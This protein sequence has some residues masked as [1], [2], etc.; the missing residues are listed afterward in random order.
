MLAAGL[1]TNTTIVVLDLSNNSFGIKGVA[2]LGDALK[3]NTALRELILNDLKLSVAQVRA[4]LPGLRAN[5]G[6]RWL[7]LTENEFSDAAERQ[8]LAVCNAHPTLMHVD[9][10]GR[11][12]DLHDTFE[13]R[14]KAAALAGTR[15]VCVSC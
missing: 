1:A 6:L 8:V 7:A 11:V 3:T 2:A 14:C 10:D 4:L 15:S 9:F 12:S 5:R 13:R